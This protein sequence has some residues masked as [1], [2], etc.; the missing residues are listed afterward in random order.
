MEDAAAV[1]GKRP[2][3]SIDLECPTLKVVKLSKNATLPQRASLGA[4][5]YDLFAAE[6]AV[7]A[8]GTRKVVKTD[9]SVGIP[10]RHYGRVAPRSGLA[11]KF[12]MDIGAGVID[13]DYTGPLGIVMINNGVKDFAIEPGDRVAQL[14]LERVSVPDVEEVESLD[15]TERGAKGFGSTG[16]GALP[17]PTDQAAAPRA[18]PIDVGTAR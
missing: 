7:I 15:A 12:G 9:L 2:T 8:P 4:A 10:P 16:T 1:L 14:L 13:S 17:T 3:P 6:A 18:V 5:G 11:Y